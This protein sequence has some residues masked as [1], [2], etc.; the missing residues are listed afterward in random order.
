MHLIKPSYEILF[1]PQ[2]APQIL[3]VCG[4]TC[5][6]SEDKITDTSA[7]AFVEMIIK[8]GHMPVL[9]HVSATVR[10]IA[11]R[12]FLAEITRHRIGVGFCV[13]STRYCDYNKKG[14]TFIIPPWENIKEGQYDHTEFY[15]YD[16][17]V[18]FNAMLNAEQAY[19]ELRE[20]GYK[21]E[22]ARSVLPNSLKTEI[23][24]TA[25]LTAWLHIFKLRCSPRAHPQ[26]RE[27][28]NP[29]RDELLGKLLPGI[30]IPST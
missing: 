11:D 18:W 7:K 17:N 19:N 9:D 27:I 21:P 3:E 16:E 23:V 24:I 29:L 2:N 22:Q 1:Y 30:V 26:M 12:G 13:E 15:D 10:I 6:K 14:V 5:Y 25:D 8:N 4:R 28:M 20:N